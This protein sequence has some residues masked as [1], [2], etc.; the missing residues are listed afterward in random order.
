MFFLLL[1]MNRRDDLSFDSSISIWTLYAVG[2]GICLLFMATHIAVIHAP[3]RVYSKNTEVNF[4]ANQLSKRS[5]STGLLL[6]S[7]LNGAAWIYLAISYCVSGVNLPFLCYVVYGILIT[8]EAVALLIPVGYALKK[9]Q[10]ILDSDTEPYY[11][12]DDEYWKK[13][14]I[15]I[16][17]TA[18]FWFRTVLTA[19]NM[20]LTSA[21]P[22]PEHLSSY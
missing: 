22:A 19:Q 2:V 1:I 4:S 10:T 16:R 8:L 17:M 11:V 5:W 7:W 18:A 20:H 13:A 12:D 9:R 6:A 14:G 3:N 15:I 21:A